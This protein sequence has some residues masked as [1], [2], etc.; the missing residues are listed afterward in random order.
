MSAAAK[1][2]RGLPRRPCRG[3]GGWGS[4]LGIVGRR[5]ASIQSSPATTATP[6]PKP[7]PISSYSHS[8]RPHPRAYAPHISRRISARTPPIQGMTKSTGVRQALVTVTG[9]SMERAAKGL[10]CVSLLYTSFTDRRE[11]RLSTLERKGHPIRLTRHPSISGSTSSIFGKSPTPHNSRVDI[12]HIKASRKRTPESTNAS[13]PQN[14]WDNDTP[15]HQEKCFHNAGCDC[16]AVGLISQRSYS[17]HAE[18]ARMTPFAINR[19][20]THIDLNASLLERHY[21]KHK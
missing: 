20:S 16:H 7:S 9:K 19:L 2:G 13:P 8:K 3:N 12:Q 1:W 21:S 14:A 10:G 15:S 6:R 11:A 5:D 17:G 4:L 18:H